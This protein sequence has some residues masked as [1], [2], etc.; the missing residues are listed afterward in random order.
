MKNKP[1]KIKIECE[2]DRPH[3]SEKEYQQFLLDEKKRKGKKRKEKMKTKKFIPY[4]EKTK[5][6]IP[7]RS[8]ESKNKW[9]QVFEEL[10]NANQILDVGI[11]P[12]AREG[13]FCV[14]Y[15]MPDGTQKAFVMGYTELGEWIEYDGTI[16]DRPKEIK[17]GSKVKIAKSNGF[18]IA[19][20]E[21]IY[22]RTFV[23]KKIKVNEWAKDGDGNLDE[24]YD[25]ITIRDAKDGSIPRIDG[26]WKLEYKPTRKEIIPV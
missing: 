5:L 1:E 10:K 7:G 2:K 11:H 26:T 14:Y 24:S 20:D 17:V 18:I 8:E 13:G 6:E 22:D 23:V 21:N 4:Y 9:K 16:S 15:E 3:C 25:E 19:G 12:S